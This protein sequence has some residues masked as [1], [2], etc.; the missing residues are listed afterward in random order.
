MNQLYNIK[1]CRLFTMIISNIAILIEVI[2]REINIIII[3]VGLFNK[4]HL[5]LYILRL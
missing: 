4:L 2:Y 3:R 1:F 5:Q